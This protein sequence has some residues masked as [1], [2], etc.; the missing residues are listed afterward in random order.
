MKQV[1]RG[2]LSADEIAA[3]I[4]ALIRRGGGRRSIKGVTI[5]YVGSLGTEANWFARPS[6]PKISPA[7]MKRFVTAL[8]QVR[9]EYDLRFDLNAGDT[10]I[11]Q[12]DDFLS[13]NE[14]Q[15][16]GLSK[17]SLH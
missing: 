16:G 4:L 13:G 12:L 5:V 1:V 17:A 11:S 15:Q 8:A 10:R 3:R 14:L 7:S 2:V 9:K 6:P